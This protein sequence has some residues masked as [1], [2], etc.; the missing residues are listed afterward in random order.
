M[1]NETET[2]IT[3]HRHY[4]PTKLCFD[5]GFQYALGAIFAVSMTYCGLAAWKWVVAWL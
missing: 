5:A 2:H 4:R 3:I 1:T